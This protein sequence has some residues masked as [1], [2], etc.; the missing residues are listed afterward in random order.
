MK[1]VWVLLCT[2]LAGMLLIFAGCFQEVE[3]PGVATAMP[4]TRIATST[5]VTVPTDTPVPTSEAIPAATI[6]PIATPAPEIPPTATPRPIAT[7]SPVDTPLPPPT[8][9][10]VVTPEPTA[11]PTPPLFL[12]VRTPKNGSE[13]PSDAVVVHGVASLGAQ[14][15]INGEPVTV[16]QDGG[17]RGEA[18]L[19]PGVNEIEVVATDAFGS[20]QVQVLIVTSLALPTLPFVL[21]ITEPAD[22][23]VV[24]SSIIRLSGRTGPEAV[25]SVNGVS[26]PLDVLGIFSTIVT[27]EPGPNIID[28]VAT[29]NDGQIMSAV[30]AVIFRP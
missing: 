29:N 2:A 16:G 14:V 9:P 6:I 5:P 17:F 27:L 25:V 21:L 7:L 10:P 4:P 8:S 30:I 26:L 24:L 1:R 28:V 13:V 15:T 12:Q 19:S 22:Q 11:V 23:S 20:R 3:R 18:A